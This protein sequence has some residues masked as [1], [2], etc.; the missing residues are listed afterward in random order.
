MGRESVGY[1]QMVSVM[2]MVGSLWGHPKH[3]GGEEHRHDTEKE[4]DL[5]PSPD[6]LRRITCRGE[7]CQP[8]LN[9]QHAQ[10]DAVTRRVNQET[11][12][13]AR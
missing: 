8:L 5:L 11:V 13:D 10:K 4:R 2:R 6:N 1:G 3:Q 9:L 7:L 12:L